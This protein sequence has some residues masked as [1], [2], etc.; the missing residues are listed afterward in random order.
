MHLIR[1]PAFLIS[2][3]VTLA[4]AALAGLLFLAPT[5]CSDCAKDCPNYIVT[6]RPSSNVGLDVR[7]TGAEGPACP[8][9]PPRCQSD[10]VNACSHISVIAA[11]PGI[12]DVTLGFGDRAW[13]TVRTQFRDIPAGTCCRG[14]PVVGENL[15]I[16]PSGTDGGITGQDGAATDAVWIWDGGDAGGAADGGTDAGAGDAGGDAP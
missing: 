6:I 3:T 4:A 11:A 1:R 8:P 2:A 7:A 13:M 16:V 10:G 5:G 15:F 14:Y 12:C 9:I